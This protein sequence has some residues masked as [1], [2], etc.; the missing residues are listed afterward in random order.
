M[1]LSQHYNHN[2]NHYKFAR[3]IDSPSP[4]EDCGKRGDRLVGVVSVVLG[5][6][7]LVVL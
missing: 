5:L 7:L 3:R 2:P 6:I 1:I 4:I